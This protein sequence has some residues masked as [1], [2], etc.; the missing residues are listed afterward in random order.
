MTYPYFDF[1]KA[2]EEKKKWLKNGILMKTKESLDENENISWIG[3]MA[4]NETPVSSVS[5]MGVMPFFSEKAADMDTLKHC[6]DV[7]KAAVG[8]LNTGQ[9]PIVCEDQ[10]IY[11]FLKLIQSKFKDNYGED[12]LVIM[13]GGF[14]LEMAALTQ[15]GKLLAGSGIDSIFVQAEVTTSGRAK[16][17]FHCNYVKRTRF[18]YEMLF[19]TL[20]ML[21]HDAHIESGETEKTEE[22][23]VES[24]K[25][26]SPT[27][28]YWDL[29][30]RL[31]K[32]AFMLLR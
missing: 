10:P 31:Q 3:Y 27:F 20:G 26:S 6:L 12:K 29:I 13:M 30:M 18:L 8:K 7:I 25:A 17:F 14:H 32:L 9:I 24:K 21:R 5:T 22:E 2:D 1:N 11:A 15:I 28:A 19:L 4:Q 23:W 16:G